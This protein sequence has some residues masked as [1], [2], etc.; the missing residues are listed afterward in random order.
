MHLHVGFRATKE[1]LANLQAHYM[2]IDDWAKGVESEDNAVLLS[3]PSVH[4]DSLAPEV[5]LEPSTCVL[6][7]Q[8]TPLFFFLYRSRFLFDSARAM[9]SCIFTRPRRKIIRDGRDWIERVPNTP[10]SRKNGVVI[11]GPFCKRSF[12]TFANDR[13]W[14]A[15]ALP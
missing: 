2:Y 9:P 4:D 3:I 10:P 12:P 11:C 1:E 7:F 14:T 8:P 13:W 6:L 5:R 15:R